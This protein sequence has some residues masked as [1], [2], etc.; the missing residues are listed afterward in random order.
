[1]EASWKITV[2]PAK[3]GASAPEGVPAL[4]RALQGPP[5]AKTAPP[6]VKDAVKPAVRKAAE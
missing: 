4:L 2:E 1:M 6:P 5:P 3:A